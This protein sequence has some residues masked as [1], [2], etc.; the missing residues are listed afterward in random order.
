LGPYEGEVLPEYAELLRKSLPLPP[1][2]LTPAKVVRLDG[3]AVKRWRPLGF[4][5]SLLA[6]RLRSAARRSWDVA[7]ALRARGIGT[8]RPVAI[9]ERW[10][11]AR[12]VESYFVTEFAEGRTFHEELSRLLREDPDQEKVLALMEPV[13]AAVRAMHDAGVVHGDMGNQNIYVD[14]VR[15]ID[16]GRGRVRELS[17]GDRAFDVSRLT[18][19]SKL[20][21]IF[22]RMYWRERW[23]RGEGPPRAF[24][25][26][27][28][29]YRRLFFW[30]TWTRPLRHPRRWMRRKRGR[31]YPAARDLWLW[32]S[33]SAQPVALLERRDRLLLRSGT[34][35]LRIAAATALDYLPV[36]RA[37]A[38]LR[39][40]CYGAPVAMADRIGMTVG[41]A[42]ETWDRE[43][44]LLQGLGRVPVLARCYA[45][46]TERE[47]E[48]TTAALRALHADG[49]KVSVALVQDRRAVRDPSRWDAF[50]KA[51]LGGL[52]G[53][54]EWIEPAHAI[55]RVK[56]GIWSLA[57]YE[58]LLAPL[59]GVPRVMGPAINDFELPHAAAA[60]RARRFDALSLHLYVDR[61]G[62]PENRQGK[63]DALGKFAL[64]RALSE[65]G[66]CGGRVIVS[67]VN[68]F[69]KDKG[70][71][72]PFAPYATPGL[73]HEWD[74]D[75][76]TYA[77]YMLRYYLH[78]ICSGMVERVYWWRLVAR[79]FGLVDPE[80]WRAR[81]AYHALKD[82]LDRFGGSTF[83]ERLPSEEGLYLLRFRDPEAVVGFSAR[84]ERPFAVRFA[85][86]PVTL[87][88]RPTC[89][90]A[91]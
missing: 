4:A 15:F 22:L 53:V 56:W 90:Q 72:H 32:D 57:E 88:G 48:F 87:T 40:Q 60:L 1:D 45:H 69:L 81:P 65:R 62:A 66:G 26:W 37:Y 67:E 38:R 44:A 33:R 54:A 35:A 82:F 34:T 8:P 17:L 27:L 2:P 91:G 86:E 28:S 18:L 59:E 11:R 29:W 68:W 51:V 19:P 25:R 6:L 21:R 42:R 14:P 5:R 70:Y 23:F 63:Y 83:V 55:N 73:A 9:L 31:A 24:L 75:E 52:G 64:A 77:D 43:L 76:E 71:A 61:R 13:A 10:E 30:H 46:E 39:A 47:W 16:L 84:G 89:F 3:L 74:V 85:T 79:P 20:L 12:L 80:G 50:V 49:W 58:R 7:T 78:A 36:K 41:P